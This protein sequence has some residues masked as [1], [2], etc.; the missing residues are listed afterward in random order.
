MYINLLF[1]G[2]Y[3]RIVSIIALSL[4]MILAGCSNQPGLS[5]SDTP[6]VP[7]NV[8][9][10]PTPPPSSKHATTTIPCRVR[11]LDL[12]I[13]AP[14]QPENLTADTAWAIAA[15]FEKRYKRAQ[16]SEVGSYN[17]YI[18][19]RRSNIKKLEN[20]YRVTVTVH[21]DYIQERDGKKATAK[22]AYPA[23]YII[24]ED[25]FIR[26]NVTLVCW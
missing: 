18:V 10:S 19:D 26:E 9:S 7:S 23:V 14:E 25:R 15:S 20:G 12:D 6:V 8:T 24:T 17:S 4:L 5:E 22:Q 13:E 2:S 3:K 11:P 16:K 21:E 1:A